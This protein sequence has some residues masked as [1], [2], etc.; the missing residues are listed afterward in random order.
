MDAM[1]FIFNR[2]PISQA[3]K[4]PFRPRNAMKDNRRLSTLDVAGSIA[5]SR[6]FNP[7][8]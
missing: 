8:T 2:R 1:R 4:R 5:V 6:S 7:T 3:G